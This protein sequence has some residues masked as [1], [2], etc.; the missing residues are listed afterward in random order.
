[1]IGDPSGKSQ[2]RNLLNEDTLKHNVDC[3]RKQLAKFL[4]FDSDAS[5]KAELVNNYEIDGIECFYSTFTN[6]Q[7]NYLLSFCKK[8]NK[9]ISGGTDYHGKNRPDTNLGVGLGNMN[10]EYDI[11]KNWIQKVQ[12][13]VFSKLFKNNIEEYARKLQLLYFTPS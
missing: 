2:E 5:N 1:M 8:N 11:V 7:T 4:D 12:K 3:I 6:E 13:F 9:Y 10:I